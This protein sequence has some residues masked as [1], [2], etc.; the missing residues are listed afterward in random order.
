MTNP[1]VDTCLTFSFEMPV[2]ACSRAWNSASH[3]CPSC[4][5]SLSSSSSRSYPEAMKPP[6][7]SSAGGSSTIARSTSETTSGCGSKANARPGDAASCR[8]TARRMSPISGIGLSESASALR[9]RGFAR[10][11][12]TFCTSLSRSRTPVRSL[13]SAASVPRSS[14]NACT[15][16]R[17]ALTSAERASGRTVQF[18]SVR[19]PIG[20]LVTSR[21][22]RSDAALGTSPPGTSCRWRRVPASRTSASSDCRIAS[23]LTCAMEWRSVVPT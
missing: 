20:V 22:P 23:F 16:S 9:S 21:T 2:R 6:S 18:L 7:A 1:N 5:I 8:V 4:E 3:L 19:A 10:I 17:R 15:R 12:S 13:L 14:T 11:E